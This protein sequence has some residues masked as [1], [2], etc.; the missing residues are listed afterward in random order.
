MEA[1]VEILCP[2]QKQFFSKISLSGVTTART[3]LF[4]ELAGDI[5]RSLKERLLLFV[6]YSV[7]LDESTDLTDTAQLAMF[8]RGVDV[9]FV[10]TEEMATLV[11][12]KGLQE[13]AI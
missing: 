9:N 12:M 13:D 10:V 6:Y 1:A 2:S 5:E 7:A 4:E 8:I 3:L 11:S